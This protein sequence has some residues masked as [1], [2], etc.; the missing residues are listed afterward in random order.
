MRGLSIGTVVGPPSERFEETFGIP[1]TEALSFFAKSVAVVQLVPYHSRKFGL[2]DTIVDNLVSARLARAFV[3]KVLVPRAL[4]GESLIFV[5]RQTRSWN[6]PRI[7]T[8][9]SPGSPIL[10]MLT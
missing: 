6:L 5:A 10:F 3:S 4:A 7:R 8:S 9:F 2:P 1:G